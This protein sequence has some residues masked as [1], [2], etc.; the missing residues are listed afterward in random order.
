MPLFLLS[1]KYDYH[2]YYGYLAVISFASCKSFNAVAKVSYQHGHRGIVC[3]GA[4]IN[5]QFLDKSSSEKSARKSKKTDIYSMG[6]T[7]VELCSS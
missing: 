5:T 2:Y 6:I 7:L 4:L 1:I 3:P